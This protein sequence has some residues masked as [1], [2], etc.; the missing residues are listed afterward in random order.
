[1][2]TDTLLQLR[3]LIGD[4][5]GNKPAP[6]TEL[7]IDDQT[8]MAVPQSPHRHFCGTGA[9]D[10]SCVFVLDAG[11]CPRSGDRDHQ[12]VCGEMTADKTIKFVRKQDYLTW[13]LTQS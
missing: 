7:V 1:M 12:Y 3:W 4:D 5:P 6:Y 11:L 10:I 2:M 9:G 8:F 13:K